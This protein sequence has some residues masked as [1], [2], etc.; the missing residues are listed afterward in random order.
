MPTTAHQS[1]RKDTGAAVSLIDQA[2]FE[3]AVTNVAKWGDTD[4]FPFPF[5]NH[6][7][8]DQP[9]PVVA[10]LSSMSRNFDERINSE[11]IHNVSL[12]APVG[13]GGFRWAT[14]IDSL[15][16]A[17]LLALVI[18]LAP[19][20]EQLRV[21]VADEVVHSYRYQDDKDSSLF[22]LDSW[23]AFQAHTRQLAQSHSYVVTADI[24]DFYSRLYHHRLENALRQ[25]DPGC[26]IANQI[27]EILKRLSNNTSYGLPVGGPAARILAELALNRVDRLLLAER[28]TSSYCR[29]ADDYRFFVNDLPSAYR[30][31]GIL[32]E[33][34]FRNEGMSLQKSKTRIMTSE[35]YVSM[36]DPIEPRPGS[37]SDFLGLHIYYDPY[38]ATADD[39]YENL[40]ERLREFDIAGLIQAELKKGR[41]HTGLTKRLIQAL[42]YMDAT[43]RLEVVTSLLDSIETL[44]PVV[45]QVM[46]AARAAVDDA[47]TQDEREQVQGKVR[48]LIR[49]SHYLAQIDLNMTYMIRVLAGSHSV[50]NEHVLIQLF[51]SPPG[52]GGHAAIIRRDVLLAMARWKAAYWLSDRKNYFNSMEAWVRRAFI[53]A[54][55]A[56]GDEGKHWRRSTN[57]SL[58][59]F[60]RII[61]DWAAGRTSNGSWQVP[62]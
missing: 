38:S 47:V 61:R 3:R 51:E 20:I 26:N 32:S 11:P 49:E 37:A 60:E 58:T 25:A 41:V 18:E 9:G 48:N 2:S 55:Y 23:A 31:I 35:E 22:R 17:Y 6:V 52:F 19:K 5:E 4:V 50:E 54:S 24:S 30:A 12:L 59:D 43:T 39:D 10:L 56:L 8:H 40:K 15:W 21:P 57:D 14:Q 36:L 16:N 13:Y 33:R 44:V 27:M 62:I 46:L 7:L 53:V 28:T 34:L 42:R 45:P 1:P 29:Y